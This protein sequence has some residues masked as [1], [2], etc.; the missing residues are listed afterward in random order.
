MSAAEVIEQIKDLPANVRA[1]AARFIA[2]NG[3]SAARH[4][5]SI[6]KK[7]DGLPA[8]RAD[9]GIITP[10]LVRKIES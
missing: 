6:S 2:E 9:G 5:V 8:I 1:Q 7:V 10:Q 4:K 3:N